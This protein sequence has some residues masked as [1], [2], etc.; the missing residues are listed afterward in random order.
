MFRD[1][2]I[3]AV[4]IFFFSKKIAF[5]KNLAK[6]DLAPQLWLQ[7]TDMILL[8]PFVKGSGNQGKEKVT[9]ARRVELEVD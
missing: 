6:R 9:G 1:K 4:I 5:S 2:P 8:G 3:I 7:S